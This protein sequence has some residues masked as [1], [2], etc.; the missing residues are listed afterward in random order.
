M[1]IFLAVGE[2]FFV[3][4]LGNFDTEVFASNYWLARKVD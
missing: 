3:F 4:M 1:E 2:T